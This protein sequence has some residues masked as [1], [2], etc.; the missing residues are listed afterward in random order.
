MKIMLEHGALM[1][2]RAHDTDAGFDLYAREGNVIPGRG[3]VVVNTGVHLEIPAGYFG[4]VSGRSGLNFVHNI[5]CPQGT[6]D[7]GYTGAIMVKLY[8][9]T[10]MPKTIKKGERIAQIIFLKHETPEFECV[11]QL[12][13]SDRGADGFGSSGR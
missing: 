5:I 9:M 3:L 12:G 10:D 6:I 4:L 8:N 11:E 13:D 7:S 2:T 1:P